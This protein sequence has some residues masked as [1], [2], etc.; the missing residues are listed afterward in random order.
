MNNE[1]MTTPLQVIK[2]G[3]SLTHS[4]QLTACL[5]GIDQHLRGH[6]VLVPGGGVFADQIRDLQIELGYS[7]EAAHRMAILAMNQFAQ[8]LLD[9]LKNANG[10]TG[11]LTA[12]TS[13]EEI[14][15]A[16]SANKI[17]VICPG[18]RLIEHM[19][20]TA[21]WSVTSDSI[22]AWI[23]KEIQA[24]Q[25]CLI[26]SIASG[27]RSLPLQYAVEEGVVDEHLPTVLAGSSLHVIWSSIVDFL[28]SLTQS[29]DQ[30]LSGTALEHSASE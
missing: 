6:A 25:L 30:H 29:S 19:P 15:P 3:G 22:A 17:P 12:V 23:A 9:R 4:T 7:D 2:I 28:S 5:S 13:L 27:A 21:S 11:A 26:K 18:L 20:F 8:Y 1:I 24:E 14:T 10:N 16:L